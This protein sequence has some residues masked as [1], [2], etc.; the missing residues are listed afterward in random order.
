MAKE[1][2]QITFA[3]AGRA[4]IL[5]DAVTTGF[6]SDFQ[7]APST[8][9]FQIYI[10]G[11]LTTNEFRI[12]CQGMDEVGLSPVPGGGTAGVFPSPEGNTPVEFACAAGDTVRIPI[13]AAAAGSV[14]AS[15]EFQPG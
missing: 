10:Q 1:Y 13:E 5:S 15:I 12:Q 14:M 7:T 11:T 6:P 8:G 3:G 2:R 4:D 9:I